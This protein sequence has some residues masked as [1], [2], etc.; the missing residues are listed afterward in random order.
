V[1]APHPRALHLRGFPAAG[2][3]GHGP[4]GRDPEVPDA[5]DQVSLTGKPRDLIFWPTPADRGPCLP[6]AV[7]AAAL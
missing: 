1:G 5:A 2:H 7:P 3:G 4:Q 6:G